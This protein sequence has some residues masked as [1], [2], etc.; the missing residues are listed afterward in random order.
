MGNGAVDAKSFSKTEGS[1]VAHPV[2]SEAQPP[3]LLR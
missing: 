2:S 3:Q 1:L